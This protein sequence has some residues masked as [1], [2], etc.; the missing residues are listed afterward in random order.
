MLD[1][2]PQL[3]SLHGE[4]YFNMINK[5]DN[6][7][8][9]LHYMLKQQRANGTTTVGYKQSHD[10][11]HPS[12]TTRN[13]AEVFPST[14]L[15]VT[16]RHPVKW[17]ESYWNFRHN[18]NGKNWTL[19]FY[20]LKH[21]IKRRGNFREGFVTSDLHVGLGFFHQ[22]LAQLG[23]T[24][25]L[26]GTREMELLE[27]EM[28]DGEAAEVFPVPRKVPNRVFVVLTEQLEDKNSNERVR[29][30]LQSF[31]RLDTAFDAIPHVRP[32]TLYISQKAI[33]R[34]KK[35]SICKPK[36]KHLREKLLRIGEVASEWVLDYF[37]SR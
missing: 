35:E 5:T 9:R 17:F 37:L 32:D 6:L 21:V 27:Y 18:N 22:F 26:N 2:H 15:I 7:K 30:D 31:L 14:P 16:L 1:S 3:A 20:P 36:Y 8:K 25:Q 12:I 28:E 24:P 13:Y 19:P 23:K 4:N 10:L 33:E 11:Y 34:S 29:K